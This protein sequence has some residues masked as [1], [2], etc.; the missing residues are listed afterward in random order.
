MD[1]KA[2][3]VIDFIENVPQTTLGVSL[4][5]PFNEQ[6]LKKY[7]NKKLKLAKNYLDMYEIVY[8]FL[9]IKK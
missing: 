1:D 8:K 9:K 7:K 3:N 2:G 6:W 4:D 5:L